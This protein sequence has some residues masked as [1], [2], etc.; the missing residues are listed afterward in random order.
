[1]ESIDIEITYTADDL[2]KSYKAH[3]NRQYPIRSK[4]VLILGI[5]LIILG[6]LLI[7]IENATNKS[8]ILGI[9]YAGLGV[10]SIL[11]FF[12]NSNT[13][14]KRMYKKMPDFRL[15]YHYKITT[16]SILITNKNITTEVKWEHFTNSLITDDMILIYPNKFRYNLFPKRYFTD[17]QFVKLVSLIRENVPNKKSI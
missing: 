11:Y 16:E 6:I 10:A 9:S 14:G 13:L 4:L 3:F 2:Q 7:A 15:P 1:M 17:E 5:L 8:E 12:W